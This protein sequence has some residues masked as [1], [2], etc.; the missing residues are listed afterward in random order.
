[1]TYTAHLDTTK[2]TAHDIED[3]LKYIRTN[4]DQSKVTW[5]EE[6]PSFFEFEER[7]DYV[8]FKIRWSDYMLDTD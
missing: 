7:D 1:M 8:T 4:L 6:F 5:S 3:M 2:T